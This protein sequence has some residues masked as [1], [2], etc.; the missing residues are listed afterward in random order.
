M[1]ARIAQLIEAFASGKTPGEDELA[2]ALAS[3]GGASDA[4]RAAADAL[5]AKVMGNAVHLRG[6]IEFSNICR[7]NCAYCGIRRGNAKV[8]RYRIPAEEILETARR[9]K[10]W[11]CGTI[12]LQSGEDPGFPDDA[13]CRLVEKIKG[14]T[15]TAVTLSVGVRPRAA[16]TAFRKAGADRYLLRFETSD[17]DLF[18]RIHP[19]GSFDDRI[20]CLRDLRAEGFQVG[21]G[22][23][24]G[25]PGADYR[26]IARDLLFAQSLEL[27]MIGCGPFIAHPDTPLADAS[28]LPLK[29]AYYN[30]IA[31]LR[32]MNPTAHIPATT[33]F[34]ALDPDG[35]DRVLAGGANVFMPNLTPGKY[36]DKYLLYPGKP[37]VDEDGGACVLCIRGRLRALGRTAGTGRGD[38]YRFSTSTDKEIQP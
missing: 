9:A 26:A 20:A 3:D 2:F 30:A 5:R 35:R 34:D 19:D 1:N 16:L 11:G 29:T 28:P 33:A 8:P 6:I 17:R 36:R 13:L 31:L 18:A 14:E 24:I 25:L 37:C 10:E 12:V 32:L 15:G 21:S 38:A 22:F 27:D 23:M 7:N 4:L